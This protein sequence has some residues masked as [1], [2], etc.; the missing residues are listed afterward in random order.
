MRP[1]RQRRSDR[2][3]Y[4]EAL[5]DG[6]RPSCSVLALLF[7]V[8][9]VW[10]AVEFPPEVARTMVPV[11]LA[12][13]ALAGATYV[14][15]GR[16]R[17]P[18][19]RAHPL[20][21]VLATV[22]FANCVVQFALTGDDHLTRNVLLLVIA[23]GVCLVDPWWIAGLT[24]GIA[25]SWLVSVALLGTVGQVPRTAADLM[26][27]LCVAALASILRRR[28]LYRLLSAQARLRE[29]S[30]RCELTGLLNRRGFLDAAERRMLAGHPVTLWFLDVDDLKQVNDRHGHEA[31]DLLLLAV[32]RALEDVFPDAVVARLSGDEFAVVDADASA[33]DLERR[34]RRLDARLA[35]C[36]GAPGLPVRVSTGTAT[37]R[38]GQ[39]LG[40]V[41][42]AADA[43]MYAGKAA[44]RA[45]RAAVAPQELSSR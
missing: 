28:T 7:L 10:H 6:F 27:A 18:P 4:G 43:A 35:V 41:L 29:L 16:R 36:A 24:G 11:A 33:A 20:G 23:I 14:V 21:A 30:Q 34:R 39:D 40:E 15:L 3:A 25:T 42:G 19:C 5:A 31:G 12:S 17:L 37:A 45:A 38:S 32:A 44:K 2:H 1:S 13:A 22:T 26:I 8:F 9:A